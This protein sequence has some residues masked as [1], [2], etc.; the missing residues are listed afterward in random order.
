MP[1]KRLISLAAISLGAVLAGC[2][3]SVGDCD[4]AAARAP[5][6]YDDDGFPA[7]AG[8]ALVEVSCGQ[9]RYCHSSGIEAGERFGVPI[10]LELDVGIATDADGLVRLAHAQQVALDQRGVI[11]AQVDSRAMPPPPPAGDI[12]LAGAPRYR[13]AAGTADLPVIGTAEG[14]EILRNWLAC[15]APVIEGTTGEPTGI[16]D[17]VPSID[18]C[19]SGQ[20]MC[21]GACRDTTA[22]PASCGGCGIACG[23]DQRCMASACTC[24]NGLTACGADCVDPSADVSHCGGCDMPCGAQVCAA[25]ACMDACPAGTTDCGGSCVVIATSLAHCGGCDRACEAGESC[26]A[27]ACSCASGLTSC[28]GAC[29]DTET[30]AANCGGCGIPCGSGGSCVGGTCGCTA[31]QT[32]CGGTCIDT[33]ADPANCGSCGRACGAGEACGSGECITCGADV[34][35]GRDVQPIWTRACG[36]SGCHIGAR[37]AGS[38]SL[39]SGRSWAELVG[40]SASCGGSQLVRP[41]AVADSYLFDKLIDV[42][43]CSGTQMPK[44]GESLPAADIE[45]IRSWICHGARND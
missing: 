26:A 8:Q 43:I 21:D 5:I 17:V 7:Y 45:I 30:D 15:G 31:G 44:R 6:Y 36:G 27:G 10:G 25:N 33:S 2:E 37:P 18:T 4:M 29:V 20:A 41:G 35:Y 32:E 23:A 12:A 39:E 40:V 42:D 28:G 14:R 1:L 38:L 9:G 11:L 19:P 34:L 13:A 22:D 3:P 16:G 24:T